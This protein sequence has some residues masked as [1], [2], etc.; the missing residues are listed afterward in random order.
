MAKVGE[1]SPSKNFITPDIY[2]AEK[3]WN[4]EFKI[5]RY[6]RSFLIAFSF[7]QSSRSFSRV[8]ISSDTAFLK[9]LKKP[10][11]VQE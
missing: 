11:I 10:S 8:H 7:D 2:Q 1:S 3:I 4:S 6:S 5:I 9:N